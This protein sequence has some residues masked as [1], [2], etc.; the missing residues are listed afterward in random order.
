MHLWWKQSYISGYMV[1]MGMWIHALLLELARAIPR[2]TMRWTAT[3][4]NGGF[5]EVCQIAKN[6]NHTQE[7]RAGWEEGG[8]G[9]TE[10]LHRGRTGNQSYPLLPCEEH[11]RNESMMNRG[12][13]LYQ[14]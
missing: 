6:P 8:A 4:T 10:I 11:R 14:P 1:G 13:Q 9:L 12:T 5:W 3:L 2:G 7:W